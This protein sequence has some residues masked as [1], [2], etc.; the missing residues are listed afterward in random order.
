MGRALFSTSSLR[1]LEQAMLKGQATG[2]LMALAGQAAA[3]WLLQEM[4][5][6]DMLNR[7]LRVIVLM[8][9]GNNGG[10]GCVMA[11]YLHEAGH[12]VSVLVC[13]A[14]GQFSEE[15]ALAYQAWRMLGGR[16]FF[17]DEA[18]K[19]LDQQS[20]LC[21]VIVDALWGIGLSRA[22]H[23]RAKQWIE[24]ANALK[25]KRLSLDVPSGLSADTGCVWCDEATSDHVVFYAHATLTFLGD[26]P[27][28]HTADGCDIAG[29]VTV[30]TLGAESYDEYRLSDGYLFSQDDIQACCSVSRVSRHNVHKGSFGQLAVIGG[31]TG[32]L[33][34]L[35]LA[36]RMAIHSGVGKVYALPIIQANE[37]SISFDLLQPEVM[38]RPISDFQAL[39]AAGLSA[40]VLGVG[41]GCGLA[42]ERL[43]SDVLQVLSRSPIP[44]VYDA[45]AL[46]CIAHSDEARMLFDSI[47]HERVLT[48]HPLEAAR[49]LG[50]SS[51]AIQQDRIKAAC[52]LA[53]LYRSHVI[54]KGAGSILAD[55][56][57]RW[58]VSPIACA[59]LS[60]AGT[61]DVLAGLLGALLAQGV[62][63]WDAMQMAVW[64]HGHAAQT[65]VSMPHF[66]LM[67][68]VGLRAGELIPVIRKALNAL[69]VE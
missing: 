53:R 51:A 65:M 5:N 18:D 52:E 6:T 8:G 36:T 28:L 55:P 68:G 16:T 20:S 13:G 30:A 1:V 41:M 7:A 69:Y 32:M 64:L 11:R 26:K 39:N 37:P 67:A 33:G 2:A 66:G 31:Q 38:F 25:V 63:T 34:A 60:T 35:L 56:F 10:D 42:S 23:G 17:D 40:V 54:L 3:A 9:T 43:F 14:V 21:D 27:G 47:Q 19:F 29:R 49:L 62:P 57:G 4:N 48:P 12:D 46:T 61:G 50:C 22:I 58:C 24:C 15:T 44:A 59:A 45:D